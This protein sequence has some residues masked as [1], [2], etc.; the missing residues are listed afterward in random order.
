MFNWGR[1]GDDRI[2]KYIIEERQT[3]S[4][5]LCVH[6]CVCTQC[7]E[8]YKKILFLFIGKWDG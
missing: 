6:A 5:T 7:K 4:Q 8:N 1:P 3:F 2:S